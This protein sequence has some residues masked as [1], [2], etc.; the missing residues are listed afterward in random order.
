MTEQ[1]LNGIIRARESGKPA[2]ACFA[3]VDRLTA[4]EMTDAPSDG[5]VFEMEHDPYDMAALGDALQYMLDRKQIAATGSIVPSARC[6]AS[7][8]A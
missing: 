6:P 2:F 7:A 4:Q 5:I 1:R 3:Q 8:S